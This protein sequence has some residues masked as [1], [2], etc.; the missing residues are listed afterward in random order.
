MGAGWDRYRALDRRTPV[1]VGVGRASQ[2]PDATAWG[3]DA[4]GL[5]IQAAQAAGADSGAGDVLR[6][7]DLVA[8]PEGTARYRDAGR[9]V[10]QAVGS[11]KARSVAMALGVPQQALF[12]RCYEALLGGR[13][14]RAL[15]VGGEAA[16]RDARGLRAGLTLDA[17]AAGHERDP[18]ER[19]VPTGDI[20]D[21]VEVAA[22]MV[23][24][25]VCYALIDSALR[26][27][28]GYG[29][30]EHLAQISELWARFS[31]VAAGFPHA[32]FP[33]ERSARWLAAASE[34]NRPIASPYNKWHCS[35]MYVDQAAAV[36]MT[37]L[38][39][40]E[41]DGVDP[42]QVVFPA[43]AL[44]SSHSVP[45]TRR[46]EMHRWPAMEI[47]GQAA[48]Q[49]LARPL[50]ELPHAELY[51]CFPA[52]VRVQQRALGLPIGGTPTI[53]GGMAFAGGP[54]NNFVLQATVAMVERLR[55]HPGDLG[56]V[57]TVSGFLNKPGLAAYS[58]EP[59]AQGLLVGDMAAAA[60]AATEQVATVGDHTGPAN[61]AA[62]T[63][64]SDRSGR[65]R[66]VVVGDVP[67]GGRCV[68][69]SADPAMA[70]VATARDL[71]GVTVT[72]GGGGFQL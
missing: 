33:L 29:P 70:S 19:H 25:P 67:S 2:A 18:D 3:T 10:V 49:H 26:Y 32:A 51:S 8:V 59:V 35:Q 42:R 44:Q 23:E 55:R 36:L 72:V 62:Y 30:D 64:A 28:E 57:T 56:L 54:F 38:G 63:V 53:T 11:G 9:S 1:I 46:R 4:L 43:V 31:G 52:A 21:A 13:A 40:A 68:A 22:G 20:V 5:M 12:N 27:A 7:V 34:A 71:A 65:R 16:A 48:S 24:P 61:V 47:L 37:T 66:T 41:D 14:E 45:V 15:V 6:R 50:S 60:E 58:T 17:T 39:A 69:V